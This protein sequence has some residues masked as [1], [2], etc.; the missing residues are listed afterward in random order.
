MTHR[1]IAP[2]CRLNV[3]WTCFILQ[4]ARANRNSILEHM[5]DSVAQLEGYEARSNETLPYAP[6]GAARGDELI[7]RFV[8]T[9]SQ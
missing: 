5:K 4:G 6:T 7:A 2:V 3:M 8:T 1:Q 9:F